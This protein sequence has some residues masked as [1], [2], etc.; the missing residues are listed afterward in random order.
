MAI[1]TDISKIDNAIRLYKDAQSMYFSI[2]G[3]TTEWSST[4]P[5]EPLSTQNSIPEL[6]GMKKVNNVSLAIKVDTATGDNIISYN[7]NN[8]QLVGLADAYS[9]KATYV[10]IASTINSVDFSAPTYRIVGLTNNPAF[11]PGVTGDTIPSELITDEGNYQVID[12]VS[13]VDRTSL[14]INE[15]VIIQG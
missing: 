1:L 4:V 2:G 10:Y 5:P 8:F 14:D 13:A 9:K 11:K 3:S 15:F 7:G 12:N 6:I